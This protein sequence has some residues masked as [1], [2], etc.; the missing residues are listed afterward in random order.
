MPVIALQSHDLH[1]D[2]PHF[3]HS[4][5]NYLPGEVVQTPTTFTSS[6]ED[7]AA[8]LP[9]PTSPDVSA[10]PQWKQ[11]PAEL[12]LD[13][14]EPEAGPSGHRPVPPPPERRRHRSGVLMSRVRANSGAGGS[15]LRQGLA[16]SSSKSY[17]DL[18]KVGEE[19]QDDP[20]TG[21]ERFANAESR[22]GSRVTSFGSGLESD[23]EEMPWDNSSV[24]L[25]EPNF[26]KLMK[27]GLGSTITCT[28]GPS[29]AL[30]PARPRQTAHP[31]I[32]H[33]A[34]PWTPCHR[35]PR[36]HMPVAPSP[37]LHRPTNSPPACLQIM[38]SYSNI[39]H[40]SSLDTP[41]H[42]TVRRPNS[43]RIRWGCRG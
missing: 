43:K 8:S 17:G 1:R 18:S 12:H 9:T 7:H 35:R 30:T 28:P 42:R 15:A 4:T 26:R 21:S 23:H 31:A 14:D 36:P 13:D 22:A 19:D 34:L 25:R 29:L 32:H 41:P 10:Q 33:I 40:P 38:A 27:T 24:V 20:M 6:Q 39:S 11:A 37:F 5:S 3:G 2:R 16:M